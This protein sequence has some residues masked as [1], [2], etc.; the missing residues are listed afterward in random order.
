MGETISKA[1][2]EV[3]VIT[4]LQQAV[5]VVTEVV[6]TTR[7]GTKGVETKATTTKILGADSS[8]NSRVVFNNSNREEGSVRDTIRG[9]SKQDMEGKM[10]E[11]GDWH[12]F[13]KGTLASG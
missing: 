7:D 6:E 3:Q 9:P 13:I 8:N 12:T 11:I 2:S 10:E 5:V 4:A 1:V